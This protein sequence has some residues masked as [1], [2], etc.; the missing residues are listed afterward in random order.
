MRLFNMMS[1]VVIALLVATAIAQRPASTTK[2]NIHLR[3]LV[4]HQKNLNY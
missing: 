1:M 3:R 2:K 4:K